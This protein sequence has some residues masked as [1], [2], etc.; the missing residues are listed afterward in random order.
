LLDRRG[1]SAAAGTLAWFAAEIYWV[2]RRL[3]D[4]LV[5]A[6]LRI[7]L[8][9]H[10]CETEICTLR[11]RAQAKYVVQDFESGIFDPS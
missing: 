8:G 5:S 10:R 11:H 7:G 4:C 3:R 6:S 1:A 2:H 9:G